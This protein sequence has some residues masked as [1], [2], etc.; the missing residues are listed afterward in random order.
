[1]NKNEFLKMFNECVENGDIVIGLENE[2]C[3]DGMHIYPTISIRNQETGEMN[4]K[5]LD[6][7]GI[8]LMV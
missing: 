2:R 1:M 8:I 3:H 7:M 5:E 4:E 6:Y